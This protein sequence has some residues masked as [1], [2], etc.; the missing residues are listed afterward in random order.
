MSSPFPGMNP[1]MED[2]SVWSEVH[3]LMLDQFARQLTPQIRPQFRVRTEVTS[4]GSDQL[5]RYLE[6]VTPDW[7]VV[8]V[9]ELLSFVQKQ[10]GYRTYLN[11]RYSV[12]KAGI[13][14]LEID[15]LRAGNRIPPA[16]KLKTPYFCLL[17][18]AREWPKIRLWEVSWNDP[19]PVLPVPLRPVS[20]EAV[21]RLAPAVEQAY[22]AKFDGNINYAANP[23]GTLTPDWQQEID[24]ILHQQ[25]ARPAGTP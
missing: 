9:I 6:I 1:Y 3:A 23:P 13:S 14:L 16:A 21:L 17:C 18:R 19:L 20:T 11:K 7:E 24:T 2:S 4:Y 25:G 5:V 10:D 12:M 15:L 22:T 8:T